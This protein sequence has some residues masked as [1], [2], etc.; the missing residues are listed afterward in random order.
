MTKDML[1]GDIPMWVRWL[2]SEHV[3]FYL[4]HSFGALAYPHVFIGDLQRAFTYFLPMYEEVKKATTDL[5]RRYNNQ[6]R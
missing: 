3:V 1:I 4:V 5:P 6:L 2:R